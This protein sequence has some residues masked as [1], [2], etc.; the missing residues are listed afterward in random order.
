MEAEVIPVLRVADAD[1][2]VSWYERLGFTK[3]WEH[4]FEPGC[5]AFVSI[6]RDRARLFLS[7]HRGDAR[8]G[9]LV[10]LMASDVEAVVA[11][12]GRPAGEPPYGCDLELR[13]PDG[14]RLR[15]SRLAG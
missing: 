8:P 5:P 13:D 12:F 9:T 1:A 11:E 6:A 4:R 15:I 14:N 2:A 3:Q 10:Q 7:E